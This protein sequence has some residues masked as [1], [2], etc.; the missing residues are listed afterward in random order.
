MPKIDS[1]DA[2]LNRWLN[3]RGLRGNPFAA[4]N[5]ER[6]PNLSDYFVDVGQFDELLRATEPCV[7]FARR[8]CGKTAQRQM[9]A[10]QC[11]PLQPHSP[12]LAIT[13]TVSGF[14]RVLNQVSEDVS[15]VRSIHHV[16]A[17][18]QLGLTVFMKDVIPH[19]TGQ[20][21]SLTNPEDRAHLA[22]YVTRFA[23]H[24]MSTG[25][26]EMPA[27]L[28]LT[29]S[30]ALLY[31]FAGLVQKAGLGNCVVLVDG[32]DEVPLT[33]GDPG[34]IVTFLSP[35]LGT[36]SL[37]EC[38][39][40]AFKFFIPQELEPIL[41]A[42][43]WFRP[44]RLRLF[45]ITWDAK[46]L[47]DLTKQRLAYFSQKKPPYKGLGQLCEDELA[48]II[49]QE[50]ATLAEGLPRVTLIL[51]SALLQHH[52][53]RP[54]PPEL[55][56]LKTWE[57]VKAEWQT[58]RSDYLGKDGIPLVQHRATESGAPILQIKEGG[59]VRLGESDITGEINPKEYRVLACLYK[60]RDEICTKDM[61][62][63]E[64]WP[65]DQRDGV[66]DQA[67]AASVARLRG[68]LREFSP[69]AE[70]IQTIKTFGYRL[71]T[72]GFRVKNVEV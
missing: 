3:Q 40:M 61:L 4:R 2:R 71:Y 72:H 58:R 63:Q 64:A 68:V 47:L 16:N 67:I 27:I 24:L 49:N 21:A 29:D 17:L 69:G 1:P 39:G 31:G 20:I 12:Q 62:I 34:Q 51:A 13:Y 5:A 52:C 6:E 38:P 60:H 55:I 9:L 18:L 45:S 26:T 44:D 23:P 15:Q 42:Q 33:A 43:R 46:S 66:S 11:R 10:A 53:Q 28:D 65:G 57:Q 19:I 59:V 70:Y 14:E 36:L 50:L 48:A 37:I 54:S 41:R 32:L 25:L 35:L 30:R 8:G 7:V 22:A 56:A